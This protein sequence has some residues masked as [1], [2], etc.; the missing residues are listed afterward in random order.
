MRT[1]PMIYAVVYT[2]QADEF[3]TEE[4]R[5]Q[6]MRD[7]QLSNAA[8]G[9]TGL[10]TYQ[11]RLFRQYLE[12]P[13]PVVRALFQRIQR[14]RRHHD[15]KLLWDELISERRFPDWMMFYRDYDFLYPHLLPSH[16]ELITLGHNLEAL[17]N[18]PELARVFIA[19]IH[20]WQHT[21][22]P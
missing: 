8:L 4:M 12:G 13:E 7:C 6:L 19:A 9:I 16:G 5:M 3:W 10:L 20:D 14:D 17:E 22:H 11:N 2:S 21:A 15:V 18:N 1:P